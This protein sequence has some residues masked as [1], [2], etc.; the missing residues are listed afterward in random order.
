M[1]AALPSRHLCVLLVDD[2]PADC[3]LAQE[4]FDLHAD[5]VSVKVIQDGSSALD[6]LRAQAARHS[7]PDVVLLDVNMPGMNGFQVLSAIRE[8][9]AFRHLPVVMLTTS[10]NP[11][12]IERA[13]DLIASSYLVKRPDF[14]G[15][16]EQVE[17]FVRFWVQVR[18][19]HRSGT[20]S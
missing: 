12:D 1:S 9:P 13:Y 6:W 7:L 10:E 14:S 15:F 3:L 11:E 17:H 20:P 18:F 4:A 16:L 2:N 5:Q 19:R 8:E